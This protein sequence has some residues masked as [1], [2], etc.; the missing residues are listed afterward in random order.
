MKDGVVTYGKLAGKTNKEL[1]KLEKSYTKLN[2]TVKKGL[3]LQTRA[4]AGV[5]KYTKAVLSAKK[6]VTSF[7]ASQIRSW[8]FV[9]KAIDKLVKTELLFQPLK[10]YK[11]VNPFFKMWLRKKFL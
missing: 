7:A 8:S 11:F 1:K 9:T 2:N 5:H 10:E 4:E 3:P 6:G